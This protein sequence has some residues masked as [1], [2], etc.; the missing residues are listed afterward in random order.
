MLID[1]SICAATAHLTCKLVPKLVDCLDSRR[2]PLPW[3]H[4]ISLGRTDAE[5]CLSDNDTCQRIT[6]TNGK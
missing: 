5:M 1:M 6:L 2:M 3:K 4:K